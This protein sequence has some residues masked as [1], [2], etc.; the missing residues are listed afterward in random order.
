MLRHARHTGL[1][2]PT[3]ARRM[4]DSAAAGLREPVCGTMLGRLYV[5][6]SSPPRCS[7]PASAGRSWSR[8]IRVASGRPRRR[9][10]Y[11]ST[12]S[13]ICRSIPTPRA[14]AG[15]WRATSAPAPLISRVATRCA[16]P[17]VTPSVSSTMSPPATARWPASASS[18]PC[19]P[20]C[21]RWRRCGALREKQARPLVHLLSVKSAIILGQ[22]FACSSAGCPSVESE[23]RRPLE[24]LT[25]RASG[26]RRPLKATEREDRCR[27]IAAES[28]K[29]PS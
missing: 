16:S 10:R 8:T 29:A 20:D 21:R 23:A 17:V 26:G 12:R 6:A 7:R 14:A 27:S 2:S 28:R 24:V 11:C 1:L 9:N 25:H 3:E 18:T 5:T 19:V 22:V 15:K 4:I 13:A